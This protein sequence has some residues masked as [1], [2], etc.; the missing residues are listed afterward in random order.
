MIL[1]LFIVLVVVIGI[2]IV[3]LTIFGSGPSQESP[4]VA[5]ATMGEVEKAAAIQAIMEQPGVR[6]A[7]IVQRGRDLSLAVVVNY[8]T[9]EDYAKNVGDNFVRLVKTLGPDTPPGKD[10][11]RGSYDYLISVAEPNKHMI[12]QG[13]KGRNAPNL[14][15]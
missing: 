9:S 4:V 7:A 2:A 10:I 14:T 12:A 3:A 5:V 1:R 13:A 11:G 6:G 15:W 8:G